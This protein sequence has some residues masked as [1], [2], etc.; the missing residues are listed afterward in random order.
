MSEEFTP[1]NYQVELMKIGLEKNSI[2][3]LPTGSG[4]TFIALMIL[5]QMS[6]SLLESY[7]NGGKITIILVNTIALVDQHSKYILDHTNLTVGQYTGEMNLDFWPREQWYTEFDQHQVLIMTSQILVNLVN[8]NY[9]DLNRVNLLIFDECHRG[10]NDHSMRQLM[11]TFGSLGSPPR[12][13]GLTATLLNGNCKP[14]R[15][16]Q[17][18]LELETTYHSKVAT[19][20]GL[21]K[22]VG[23]STNPIEDFK[24]CKPHESRTHETLAK[25]ILD[26]TITVLKLI[27]PEVKR[28]VN[29]LRLQ[30]LKPLDPEDG[31]RD[32]WNLVTDLRF[33]VETMGAFGGLKATTAHL[34]QVER[35]KKH[36]QDLSFFEILNFVQTSMSFVEEVLGSAM[37][38]YDEL[39]QI[40]RFSSDKVLMLINILREYKARSKEELCC[41]IFTQRR[42]TAKVIYHVL[43]A[44]RQADEEFAHIKPNFMVGYNNNPMND[45]REGLFI[46]KKN[47]QVL[48][49]FVNKE[50]NVLV[51]SNVLEE[52]VDIPKCTL[53][54]KYDKPEDYRS[55]I[56]SKGRARHK[57]SLYYIVVERDDFTK[58]MGKYRQFQEVEETL[59]NY[60]IGKNKDRLEPSKRAIEEMYNEDELP[61]YYVDG[62]GSAQVN[63]QSAISLLCQYCN[64]LPSDIYTILA[65][66]WYIKGK[67]TSD[68]DQE[69]MLSVVILLPTICPVLDLIAGPYMKSAKVAKRA[70]ALKACEMLHKAGELDDHLLPRKNEVKEEDVSFL[71]THYPAKKELFVGSSKVRRLHK[72]KVAQSTKGRIMPNAPAFLHVVDLAPQFKRSVEPN[73]GHLYDAFAASLTFGL[74]T[75]QPLP[76]LCDFPVYPALGTVNVHVKVNRK[77]VSLTEAQLLQAKQFHVRVFSDVLK[78]AHPFLMMDDDE[79]AETLLLVPVDKSSDC[80]D[81]DSMSVLRRVKPNVEPT[82]H[83]KKGLRVGV[84]SHLGKIVT[85]WYRNAPPPQPCLVTEICHDRDALSRFTNEDYNCTFK[86]YFERRYDIKIHNPQLP[87]LLTKSLTK[88]KNFVKPKGREAKRK[89]DRANEERPQHLLPELVVLQDFP[90]SLWVQASLLPTALSRVSFLLQVEELRAQVAKEAGLGKEVVGKRK[91]L[92]LDEYLI[93]YEAFIEEEAETDMLEGD[94][95]SVIPPVFWDR[96][97]DYAA[98]VTKM[99]EAQYPW[100]D[101]EE[102]K[103]LERDLTVSIGDVERYETFISQKP[104]VGKVSI[105]SSMVDKKLNIAGS[106]EFVQKPLALLDT[107]LG[108]DGP[109]L[110]ELYRALTAAKANDIVN[111]ERLETLGDSFLKLISSVYISLRFPHY[112]EGRATNLKSR[113]V[114]NKNLYYLAVRK[115][116]GGVMK[117]NELSPDTE[118]L[119]TGFTI[120]RLMQDRIESKNLSL[121]ALYDLTIPEDEQISGK[122]SEAT[123]EVIRRLDK[124]PDDTEEL[125][126]HGKGPFL[127]SQYIGDKHVAD[128]VESLLGAYISSCGILGGIKFV[129]WMGIV[130]AS[131]DLAGM[132]RKPP[133]SP[134]LNK[135]ATQANIDYH[136]PHWHAVERILGYTFSNRAYLLQALTHASYTPNRI[137]LSYEKLE[138]LGDAILDFLITCHIYESC[139]NL[140]PG[141]LTDLRSALVNN[142]TFASLVVRNGLHKFLLMINSTLQGMIDKFVGIMETKQFEI[143]DQVLILL[144]EQDY[145][146]AESVDV[147][148]ILG[149]MFEALAG[150]VYLDSN[151]DLKTVWKVFYRLMYKEIDLFSKDVPMNI[152]RRLF[153]CVGA[154]PKFGESKSVTSQKVMVPLQ[155]SLKGARKI[156]HGFG[157]NKVMAKRAA[158]KM[159]LRFLEE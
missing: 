112:D 102:P 1:R 82:T 63:M 127:K 15:V 132:L 62:P 120:P 130:P 11:K 124:V 53:V 157:S 123:S 34:V 152:I 98:I 39:S 155:F 83:E 40:M 68:R 2:I 105:D 80:I 135:E 20:D 88:R 19:V 84:E 69:K 77:V 32:L 95:I 30:G 65:P 16:M 114:S 119:P 5:K 66:E 38:G 139:G 129:E 74:L 93:K 27:H 13:I 89:R 156:V 14:T 58:Y 142:N 141:Q 52:G 113:L 136:L 10:V 126:Y 99:L 118:W 117:F 47:K 37:R 44:L 25:N 90:A 107:A 33:H 145:N 106:P 60:L 72:K 35:I 71:F 131:E 78:I 144:E 122:L 110:C 75:A 64:C 67:S 154:E 48:N 26:R 158:A 8:N 121:R 79:E 21:D 109:E 31:Y 41:L 103:D 24:I 128:V 36:C 137:T 70:A 12:V 43:D 140:N 61:P 6:G 150:A 151:K 147:P 57:D 153:E 111:L 49:S 104:E 4:K 22:V 42:F 46:S 92:R 29:S 45:T 3:F 149:D 76:T 108:E 9:M 133:I 97:Q 51:A 115:E 101:A 87:L 134:V 81:F 138:F 17:A 59:N 50:I 159:A 55:Y 94:R 7:C 143:D 54:I 148:K 146:M 85:L 100:R 86:E 73:D 116:L 23:Y 18:V 125:S 56:Q 91:P 28:T 96:N